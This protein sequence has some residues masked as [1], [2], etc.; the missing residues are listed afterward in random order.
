MSFYLIF[1]IAYGHVFEDLQWEKHVDFK[2]EP[3][4]AWYLVLYRHKTQYN[5]YPIHNNF[6]SEFKK[7]IFG[8]STSSL[9]ME[10]TI[11]LSRKR[12]YEL[13]EE[14]T[15]IRLFGSKEKPFLLPFYTSD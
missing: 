3:V 1:S 11:F 7:I 4:Y 12:V 15:V 5:F 9:S 14:F 8:Q 13:F 6:I 2:L 10:E